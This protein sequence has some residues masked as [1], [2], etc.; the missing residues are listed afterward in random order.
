ML[1]CLVLVQAMTKPHKLVVSK[2]FKIMNRLKRYFVLVACV[3]LP[4]IFSSCLNSKDETPDPNVQIKKEVAEIDSYL[5]T[6]PQQGI[7][8]TVK[9]P[10]GMRMVIKK[11]GTGLPARLTS[12]TIK[13]NYIGKL[14]S[15]GTEFDRGVAQQFV[16]NTLIG[17]WQIAF[18]TLPEGSI[19]TLYIPSYL[20]YGA[21]GRSSIPAN[22]ILVFDV[23]FTEAII[24]TTELNKLGSDTVAIDNYLANKL[25]NPIVAQ[26][27]TTGIRYV[28][29]TP[30]TGPTATWYDKVTAKFT[31]KSITDDTNILA[32]VT[33]TPSEF[34]FSRPVDYVN[35]LKVGLQKLGKGGKATFYIPSGLGFG[36][37]GAYSN[38]VKVIPENTNLIVEVEITDITQ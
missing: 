20:A 36:V 19:A 12:T 29:T 18:T 32:S 30:G 26:K 15:N 31:Y 1:N 34:F 5:A 11:L 8:T 17:G 38:N 27:D 14:F 9:D 10:S 16:L 6:Q 24:T 7:V 37:A 28:I 23:V 3:G 33:Q 4:F 22:S 25:P 35:G 2:F 21:S 13:I